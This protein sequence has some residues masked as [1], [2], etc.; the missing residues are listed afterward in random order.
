[1]DN[2]GIISRSVAI[3]PKLQSMVTIAEDEPRNVTLL[4]LHMEQYDA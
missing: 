2:T 1:M 3:V 4:T